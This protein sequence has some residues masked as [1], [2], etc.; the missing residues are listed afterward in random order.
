MK[1]IYIKK[2][3]SAKDE[4]TPKEKKICFKIQGYFS[5]LTILKK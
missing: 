5:N 4:N 3:Y 1:F 2:N